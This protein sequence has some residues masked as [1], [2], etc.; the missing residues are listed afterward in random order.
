VTVN[1]SLVFKPKAADRVFRVE[2]FA[3]DDFGN[4]QGFEEVGIIAVLRK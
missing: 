4:Q 2:A 3:T 1:Y